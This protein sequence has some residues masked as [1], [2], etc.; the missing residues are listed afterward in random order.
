[1]GGAPGFDLAVT[2]LRRG[3]DVIG[4]DASPLA[5]GLFIS[6]IIPR[7]TA[8]ADNPGYPAELLG[9]C[10]ELRPA[11]LFFAVEHKHC[12]R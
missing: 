11:A 8:S 9:L 3:I 5:P 10:A 1:M 6:G 4:T 12:P 7:V 2:L